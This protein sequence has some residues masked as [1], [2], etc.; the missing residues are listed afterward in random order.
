LLSHNNN[1]NITTK[2][3]VAIDVANVLVA[4]Q[5]SFYDSHIDT[6][7]EVGTQMGKSGTLFPMTFL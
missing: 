4:Y 7:F 1:K 2:Q 3:L 5:R 6:A